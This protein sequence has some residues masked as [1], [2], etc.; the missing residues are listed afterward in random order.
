MGVPLFIGG[1]MAGECMAVDKHRRIRPWHLVGGRTTEH[2]TQQMGVLMEKITKV[3]MYKTKDGSLFELESDAKLHEIK[4]TVVSMLQS[5]MSKEEAL[6]NI[7]FIM[8]TL[9]TK[10]PSGVTLLERLWALVGHTIKSD[11]VAG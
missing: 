2:A 10:D 1:R 3:T 5:C 8:D 6:E 4:D 7:D 11:E 9:F